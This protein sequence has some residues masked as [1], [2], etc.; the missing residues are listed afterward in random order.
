ME[1]LLQVR[2]LTIRYRFGTQQPFT[3]V[4]GVSFDIGKAEAVGLMGGS[5]CGKTSVALAL[6]GLLAKDRAEITGSARFGD[7]DLLGLPERNFQRIRGAAI[8]I[9]YQEPS[10][11]LSP[12][13][14]AGNQIAEV[15][16]AHRGW[17]WRRC[18][19]EAEGMLERVGLCDTRRIFSAYPHQLSG[20]QCQRVVLAQALACAPSLLIADE[21]TAQLD[22]RSQSQFL[23]FLGSLQKQL[24]ISV[25]VISHA[26]EV[27]ASLADRLL[28]ME[29]GRII[30][31]GPFERLYRNPSE[32]YTR[33]ILCGKAPAPAR[34]AY[35]ISREERICP[36]N[37]VHRDALVS[38]RGL[39][40]HYV[41]KRPFSGMRFR[42][43]ALS[44]V[45]L[46]IRRG[47][48]LALVGES[49][50][51]KSTLALCLALLEKPTHGEIWFEGFDVRCLTR[52]ELLRSR[53]LVQLI[54][55][56]PTSS[57]DPRMTAAEIIAEPLAIQREGPKA[58]RNARAIELMEQVGLRTDS[59]N[60]RPLE[61]SGGQ[62]QRLAIARS[63]ALQ[64]KLLILDEAFSNLDLATRADLVRLLRDLQARHALTYLLI[65]HDLR[66]V[67]D[68][69][70]EVAV[71]NE[72]RIIERQA[73]AKLFAHPEHEYTRTL[74]GAMRLPQRGSDDRIAAVQR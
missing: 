25:L 21:P 30:E 53:R 14:S 48:T 4:D 71:M 57:L 37:A 68:L 26:P 41:Q 3:A 24:G 36:V 33:A 51:G 2:K 16:H 6:L 45:T 15:I 8:S 5:G 32:D 49:G 62:R 11:A 38:V 17:G 67:S 47:T 74:L 59:A 22:A 64:P 7:M 73:T 9:V 50:A 72:G 39:S 18:Q 29:A 44:G 10:I 70:D 28:V 46:A 12:V 66:M 31:N 35:E 61:F 43:D 40:K 13:I 55:Q 19:I 52:K 54:F 34:H 65:S 42:V 56:D 69:A 63:L 20:G 27:Q 23:D 58:Y 1:T 60:K